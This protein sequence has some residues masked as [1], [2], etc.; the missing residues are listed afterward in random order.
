MIAQY[1]NTKLMIL[2][3]ARKVIITSESWSRHLVVV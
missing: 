1:V 3:L 2:L